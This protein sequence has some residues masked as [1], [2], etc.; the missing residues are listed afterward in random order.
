MRRSGGATTARPPTTIA[1]SPLP[2]I[3]QRDGAV[4]VERDHV[5][6]GRQQVSGGRRR[7]PRP[8]VRLIDW[9][10]CRRFKRRQARSTGALERDGADDVLEPS[11]RRQVLGRAPRDEPVR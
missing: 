11:H 10:R 5:F 2:R 8:L 7:R 1:R 4:V 9:G 6:V 3:H